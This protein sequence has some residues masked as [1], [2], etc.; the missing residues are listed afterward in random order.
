M[1]SSGQSG[2]APVRAEPLRLTIGGSTAHVGRG[3]RADPVRGLPRDLVCA[4]GTSIRASVTGSSSPCS[5]GL[6]LAPTA[7][8]S[9]RTL[10]NDELAALAVDDLVEIGTHTANHPWLAG[11]SSAEPGA[12]DRER[13][14]R[15]RSVRRPSD[16]RLRL[17]ARGTGRHRWRR[18][19]G[20]GCR[21]LDSLPGHAGPGRTRSSDR[22]ALPRLF[23]ED[24]DGEGFAR[25]LWRYAGIRVS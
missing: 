24:M 19:C 25:L 18:G 9:H 5:I 20:S 23:V 12:P 15:A 7:R 10:T 6:V 2:R 8:P 11:L 16:R 13:S 1:R 3:H 21:A 14:G 17:S 4:A 22:L